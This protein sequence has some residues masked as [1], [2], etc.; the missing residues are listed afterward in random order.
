MMRDFFARSNNP[1]VLSSRSLS[2][3]LTAGTAGQVGR[4]S[5]IDG[6]AHESH[7]TVA[8]KDSDPTRV[9]ATEPPLVRAVQPERT[10]VDR[11][12]H[13]ADPQPVLVLPVGPGPDAA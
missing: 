2:H 7:G 13:S 8:E 5:R 6:V 3:Y 4:H 10:L 1:T 11:P 9:R 12:D